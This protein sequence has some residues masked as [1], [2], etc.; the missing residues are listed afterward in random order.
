[1]QSLSD[2][3]RGNT[4]NPTYKMTKCIVCKKEIFVHNSPA[5]CNVCFEEEKRKK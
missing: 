2:L 1:M 3:L 5:I 4:M